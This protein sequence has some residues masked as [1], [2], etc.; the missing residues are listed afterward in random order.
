MVYPKMISLG[1][2]KTIKFPFVAN[3]KLMVFSVPIVKKHYN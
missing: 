1:T 3:G 2:P